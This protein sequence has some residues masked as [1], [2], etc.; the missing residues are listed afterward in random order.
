P[1]HRIHIA[2]HPATTTRATSTHGAAPMKHCDRRTGIALAAI[3][4]FVTPAAAQTI[5]QK[6][7]RLFREYTSD[8]RFLPAS[9]AT[10]PEHATIPSPREHFGTII[11]APGVMHRT[12]EIHEYYEA[13]AAATPRVAMEPI[14]T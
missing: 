10:I 5:D 8:P 13:L 3:L 9:L 6:Y 1:H 2:L 4:A 7:T 11:G 14:G 12:A